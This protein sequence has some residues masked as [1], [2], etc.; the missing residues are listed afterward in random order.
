MSTTLLAILKEEVREELVSNILPFWMGKMIDARD[1]GF[2]GR[3]DG[4]GR[5]YDDAGKGCVLN[6]RILWT[7]SAAFRI[8]KN[9]DYLKTAERSKDY[10]LEHFFDKDYGGVFWLLDHK[11]EMNDG[12]KQIYA[13]A[14]SIY[15]LTEYYR[16]TNDM[17][18]LDKA[19]ELFRLI[20]KF[21]YD[22]KFDGY[23]EAFSREWGT[24]DDLRLSAKDA[25][26]KKTMNTHLHV[27]E[28]YT[29]L[30]RIWKDDLLKN[31][32]R[33]LIC[34][35]TDRIVNSQT[36]NLNMFF[37]E[38]WNDKT[39]LVSYGHNIESAWLI[40]EAALVLEDELITAKVKKICLSIAEASKVGIMADGSMIYEKFFR[41]GHTDTDRHW[42]VQAE[43]VVGFLN[44]F[45]LSGKEE[46]L[47][48]SVAA[49]RFI[50]DHLVD[51]QNGEWYWS[52]DNNLQPN[53]KEDKAGFWKCPYH[54]SRM[55]LEIIERQ[56]V[57]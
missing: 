21:S 40:Y 42:W 2:F 43:T 53:L 9:T 45:T 11:G 23:F 30:Y 17:K 7:F 20:E 56:S 12:K 47:D 16:I 51:R 10:L 55:C 54:D 46:Y 32:L 38:E 37:D 19:I 34:V 29:N 26:E 39:D 15:G 44:A 24:L 1:G 22:V 57:I 25:N 35:F 13:Q 41:S 31:Q 4:S 52:V 49:W 50:S 27:L 3:I 8:L 14:F 36:Y 18:C 48:M 6:A 28:A 33:K 5:V